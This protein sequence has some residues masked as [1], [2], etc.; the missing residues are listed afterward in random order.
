[1]VT[2]EKQ[3][4]AAH[5]EL[6]RRGEDVAHRYLEKMGL[7]V[8]DRNWRCREGELDIIA[9]DDGSLVVCEVKTRTGVGFGLPAEAITHAKIARIRRLTNQWL[10]EKRRGFPQV[11]FDVVAIVWPPEG[12][13]EITHIVAAF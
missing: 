2:V 10:S 5:L 6:G 7:V 4:E 12:E 13:P 8:V 1:M 9:V 3:P 11:R